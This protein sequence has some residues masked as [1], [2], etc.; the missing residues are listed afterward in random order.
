MS[1]ALR[2]LEHLG[3]NPAS[4][5]PWGPE[6]RAAVAAIDASEDQRAAISAGDAEA[7]A[8]S[9]GSS[10]TL[11]GMLT[12]PEQES[13]VRSPDDAPQG[14]EPDRDPDRDVRDAERGGH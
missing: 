9:F 2:F 7:L 5:Q 3:R 1:D 8:S 10:R 11:F 6:L 14:D 13:P 4:A 12:T